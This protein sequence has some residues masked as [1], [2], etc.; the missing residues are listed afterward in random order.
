[1]SENMTVPPSKPLAV[2][3]KIIKCNAPKVYLT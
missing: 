3:G 2:V 1:M